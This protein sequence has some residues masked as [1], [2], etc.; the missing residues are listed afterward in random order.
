MT[1]KYSFSREGGAFLVVLELE[2]DRSDGQHHVN[3]SVY[4]SRISIRNID[5]R[6]ATGCGSLRPF[7]N[8]MMTSNKAVSREVGVFLDVL[9]LKMG[10]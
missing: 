9:E 3:K 5:S 8:D 6:S 2:I 4:T 7:S 1:S 10:Q